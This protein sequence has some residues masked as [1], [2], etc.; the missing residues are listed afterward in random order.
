MAFSRSLTSPF[1]LARDPPALHTESPGEAG[2]LGETISGTS[3][4][5]PVDISSTQREDVCTLTKF[6]R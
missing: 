5:T 3:D 1:L 2:G 6:H 4:E